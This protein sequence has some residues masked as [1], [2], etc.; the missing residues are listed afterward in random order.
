MFGS[1]VRSPVSSP[2]PAQ[3]VA[4]WYTAWYLLGGVPAANC[5]AAY[6]PKG[7][8]NFTASLRNIARPGSYDA[9][10]YPA[11]KDIGWDAVNGWVFAAS[12]GRLN[13]DIL[14]KGNQDQSMILR[15]SDVSHEVTA[16]FG[17][18]NAEYIQFRISPWYSYSGQNLIIY[19]NGYTITVNQ[20]VT[21][22]ILCV[23]GNRGYRNGTIETGAIAGY[24]GGSP[25]SKILIGGTTWIGKVQ[26]FAY[27]DTTLSQAQITAINNAMAL[28]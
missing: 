26:A 25:T 12:G 19:S 6:Q 15:L 13:T 8:P 2:V 4:P 20:L 17:M 5:I 11:G 10:V 22:G 24:G 23:A 7:A 16:S 14:P 27:Y 18:Y 9:Y 21:S 28:L 3:G 1:M